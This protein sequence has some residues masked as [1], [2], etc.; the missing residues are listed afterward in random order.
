MTVLTETHW[1]IH[2]LIIHMT[3][4]YL[5]FRKLTINHVEEE[6]EGGDL[7]EKWDQLGVIIC[8][9]KESSQGSLWE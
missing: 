3:W 4:W 6:L 2:F 1:H 8:P 5:N 9:D 7:I